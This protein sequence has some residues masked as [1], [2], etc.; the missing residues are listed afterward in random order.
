M[1][2]LVIIV[3]ICVWIVWA[4]R[5]ELFGSLPFLMF[6][7]GVGAIVLVACSLPREIP[8]GTYNVNIAQL[9][10]YDGGS[11]SGGGFFLGWS[12]SGESKMQYVIMHKEDN[13]MIRKFLDQSTTYV[14]ET[15]DTPRVE[16]PKFRR[17]RVKYLAAPW[18][19]RELNPIYK[20]A[21]ATIYVPRGTVIFKFDK[22]Q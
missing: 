15:D 6:P 16:Y 20:Q 11:I 1:I 21:N 4:C 2:P 7:L 9:A 12:V 5:D 13:G 14:V 10:H 22:I 3:I 8:D 17:K 19:D 18:L